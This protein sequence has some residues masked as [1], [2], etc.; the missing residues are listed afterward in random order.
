MA[1][2]I[3]PPDDQ[4]EDLDDVVGA[5]RNY[6]A[7]VNTA[8][9]T[10]ETIL[11]QITKGNIELNPGFQRREAWR[12][13]RKS[14]YIESLV[15]G[16]PVPQIV[17]AERRDKKGAFVV[18]DGKQRLLSLRQFAAR[19][20]DKLYDSFKLE[21]LTERGD[22]N[23][24]GY[25]DF[26]QDLILADDRDALD[27]ATIRT[28]VIRNWKDENFLYTVFLR[29]NTGSVPL[30]P[31]ELRQ[32]LHPGPFVEFVDKYSGDCKKLHDV[33]GISGADGRMRDAELVIRY[34]AFRNLLREYAGSMK[35]ILDLASKKYNDE[36]NAEKA[37]VDIQVR[38]FESA[39]DTV[40]DIFGMRCAF[41]KWNGERYEAA[42]NR[43]VFDVMILFFVDANIAAAARQRKQAVEAA[44]RDLC[45]NSDEFRA[46][47]EGTTKSLQSIYGR[48]LLWSNA[49]EVAIERPVPKPTLQN[50]RIALVA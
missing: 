13:P 24:R 34:I 9:W 33:M 45:A 5:P 12:L 8:D 29:L 49:L 40:V 16:I 6:Q 43:A 35:D 18:I 19:E 14:K 2:I 37:N 36:W 3:T 32:A 46:S 50:N 25:N 1:D 26:E 31:Q 27:N 11:Q 10:V 22:L 28:A 48:L 44:F 7:V 21:G 30:S 41:R 20:D 4:Q 39:I 42:L 23:G 38:E 15:M 17:L 47:V